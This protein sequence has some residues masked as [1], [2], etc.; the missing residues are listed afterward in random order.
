ML[1]SPAYVVNRSRYPLT[2]H[3]RPQ[4]N[5]RKST[6]PFL[7]GKI[8]RQKER[9]GK[10]VPGQT[11]SDGARK[12]ASSHPRIRRHGNSQNGRSS[13]LNP[14]L[15]VLMIFYAV[16]L[17]PSELC[18]QWRIHDL[19]LFVHTHPTHRIRNWRSSPETGLSHPQTP[20]SVSGCL[21]SSLHYMPPYVSHLSSATICH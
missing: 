1:L 5:K 13:S 10:R 7:L 9:Q 4:I 14:A 21:P 19:S 18:C 12:T 16:Y 20:S 8:Q 15:A 17:A 6:H 2:Y 11:G 3:V